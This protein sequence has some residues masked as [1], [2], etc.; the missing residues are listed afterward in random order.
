MEA[1]PVENCQVK[2]KKVVAALDLSRYSEITFLSAHTLARALGAE[3]VLL[4]VI[5]TRYLESF[6]MVGGEG[7]GVDLEEVVEGIRKERWAQLEEQFLARAEGVKC[8]LEMRAGL[9]W[10][11]IIA[12]LREEG[13]DMVV[14]GAKGHGDAAGV[15]FGSVAEKVQR[16]SPCAVLSVRGPEHCRL[17]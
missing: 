9:P 11:Q 12:A 14:I 7:F 2:F 10:E 17:P 15:L 16:H 5:N 4:N 6:H 3:L 1:A 8:R 13:A